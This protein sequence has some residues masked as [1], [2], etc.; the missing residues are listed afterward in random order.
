M[1]D[2]RVCAF[3]DEAG[4]GIDGQINALIHNGFQGTGIR[5]VD[6]TNVSDITVQKAKQ[7]RGA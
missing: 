4:A 5:N 1:S 7:V 3:S 2:I 6:G